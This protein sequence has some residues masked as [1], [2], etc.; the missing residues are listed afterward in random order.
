MEKRYWYVILGLIVF[1]L[2][3]LKIE[4]Q[5]IVIGSTNTSQTGFSFWD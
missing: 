1:E 2:F 4:A 5:Q 3:A